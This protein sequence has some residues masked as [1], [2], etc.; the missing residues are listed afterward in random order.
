MTITV[1]RAEPH[2]SG[3]DVVLHDSVT[4]KSVRC[5][6]VMY[7]DMDDEDTRQAVFEEWEELA[8]AGEPGYEVLA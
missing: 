6:D 5:V 7:I 8:A 4:N 2:D 3:Y 1:T